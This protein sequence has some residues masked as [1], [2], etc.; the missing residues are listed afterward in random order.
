MSFNFETSNSRGVPGGPV[1]ETK[2]PL[3]GHKFYPWLGN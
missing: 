2:L 3:R 1:V